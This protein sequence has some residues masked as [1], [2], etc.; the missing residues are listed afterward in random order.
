[1]AV[2]GSSIQR[3]LCTCHSRGRVG[4]PAVQGVSYLVTLCVDRSRGYYRHPASYAVTAYIS[5]HYWGGDGAPWAWT[6]GSGPHHSADKRLETQR[7]V[8]L[9]ATGLP[10]A[11]ATRLWTK[12]VHSGQPRS[13]HWHQS[14]APSGEHHLVLQSYHPL[15]TASSDVP[16]VGRMQNSPNHTIATCILQ[17]CEGAIGH[18]PTA[19]PTLT[20]C[21]TG[22]S[23]G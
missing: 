5:C 10:S 14:A 22:N 13:S 23:K 7:A 1:M 8:A 6:P 9:A 12:R 11:V 21:Y 20:E 2:S 17:G 16:M 15:A 19:D 18:G 4:R 3:Y